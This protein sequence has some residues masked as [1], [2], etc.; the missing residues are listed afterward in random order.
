MVLYFLQL[1][2]MFSKDVN[3]TYFILSIFLYLLSSVQLFFI[4]NFA[5][6][7]EEFDGFFSHIS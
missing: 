5:V 1:S 4:D 2:D 6:L 3:A 7:S